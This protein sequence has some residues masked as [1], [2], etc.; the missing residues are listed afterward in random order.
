MSAPR[1]EIREAPPGWP[2]V[3]ARIAAM[4]S[5]A[6]RP[7]VPAPRLARRYGPASA[8]LAV[9][10]VCVLST[11]VSAAAQDV[12]DRPV[13]EVVEQADE[14]APQQVGEGDQG[15]PAPA[16]TEGSAQAADAAGR[17]PQVQAAEDR[18]REDTLPRLEVFFPEG[19]LDLRVN[20]LIDKVFFEGQVQYNFIDG[21]ISAFLRYRYY[22]FERTYQI[23]GFDSIEFD[24]IE[25]LSDEFQ[26]TRGFLVLTQWP[27]DYSHRS[28]MLAEIDRLISNKVE[29]R[30]D[31]NSTNTYLRFGY[32]IGTPNDPRS[33]AIV[34]ERRAEVQRLFTPYRQIGP[35]G[36]GLTAA[37][38]WGI[39]A[40]PGDFDY[41]KLESQALKRFE[42]P[43]RTFLFGR[44][45]AGTFGRKQQVDDAELRPQA[46]RFTIPRAE[47]FR[48]DGRDNLK[49]V[50]ERV[51]GTEQ[52]FTT[53]EYFVPWFLDADHRALGLTWQNWYWVLY[54][55]LG[56][57]GFERTVYTDFGTYYPDAGTGFE[58]SFRYRKYAFFLSG[59]VAQ[60]FRG[61]GSLEARVSIKSYR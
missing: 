44:L 29:L 45:H 52:L 50:G 41:V 4:P 39:E 12:A 56:T 18:A 15:E 46:D 21:D 37:V 10:L 49:G 11:A 2:A 3:R 6:A 36:A 13:P 19:D 42:L 17:S 28:F 34:G 57:T 47:L 22:G 7:A 23:T 30:F 1:T 20:R 54:A 24:S 58:C 9:A 8:R 40:G 53:W 32:Q 5:N 35:G 60:A 48:L 14:G 59:V 16:A 26:R 33:N 61:D 25:K 43:G 27:L 38:T 51:R 31:N 55:G